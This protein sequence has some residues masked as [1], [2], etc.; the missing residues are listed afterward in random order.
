MAVTKNKK[1]LKE[2]PSRSHNWDE[3]SHTKQL[4]LIPFCVSFCFTFKSCELDNY[5]RH[6]WHIHMILKLRMLTKLAWNFRQTWHS[7][8]GANWLRFFFQPKACYWTAQFAARMSS[9]NFDHVIRNEEKMSLSPPRNS[10]TEWF[11]WK[12]RHWREFSSTHYWP[13]S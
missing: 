6:S 9:V 5:I 4:I 13:N 1:E 12:L 10:A 2:T 3:F 11:W 8:T 7:S